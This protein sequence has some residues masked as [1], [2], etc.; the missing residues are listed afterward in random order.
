LFSLKQASQIWKPQTQ[1]Q[2][3]GSTLPQ[4]WH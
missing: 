2:Q 3:K 1:F 4:Q